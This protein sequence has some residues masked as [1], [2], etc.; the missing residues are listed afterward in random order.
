VKLAVAGHNLLELRVREPA[1]HLHHD[2]L[3]HL[4]GD[5]FAQAF[6]TIP[7]RRGRFQ[8]FG[9]FSHTNYAALLRNCEMRVSTRAM[10]LR[11]ARRRAG[12]SSCELAC[13]NRRLNI[14]WRRSRPITV[15]S[16]SVASFNFGSDIFIKLSLKPRPNDGAK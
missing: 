6:F 1:F 16:T 14:S 10:S 7:A 8:I 15:S 11:S 4:V 13:C 12:F 9:F 3:R 5:D 2:G